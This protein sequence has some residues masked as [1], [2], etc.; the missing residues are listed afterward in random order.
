[1]SWVKVCRVEEVPEWG[2]RKVHTGQVEIGL[3]RLRDG[4]ILAVENHCPHKGGPLS[5]GIVTG[6]CVIC[7]LH[8]W[9]ICLTTGLVQEPDTG[10]VRTF[11]VKVESGSVCI[12][13]ANHAEATASDENALARF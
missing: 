13:L 10:K 2:A 3:F 9:R 7:P 8:S 6:D 12:Q 5:E 11:P 4:R 1:M